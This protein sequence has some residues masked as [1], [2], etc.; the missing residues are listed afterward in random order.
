[1]WTRGVIIVLASCLVELQG[2]TQFIQ[3]KTLKM[4]RTY[5]ELISLNN[6]PSVFN[7]QKGD[8]RAAEARFFL[9][10]FFF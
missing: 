1:M 2:I 4:L 9:I 6:L 10:N 3:E 8:L 7:I 5:F